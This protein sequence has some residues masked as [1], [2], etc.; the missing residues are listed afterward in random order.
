MEEIFI[1]L[2]LSLKLPGY[3]EKG[4]TGGKNL[5]TAWITTANSFP[6]CWRA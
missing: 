3:G 5:Q 4:L 6:L 2:A 1:A